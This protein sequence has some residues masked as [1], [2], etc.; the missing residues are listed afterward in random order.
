MDSFVLEVSSGMNKETSI[1]LEHLES[2][3][4]APVIRNLI[5]MGG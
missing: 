5:R 1:T 2:D 4:D 3:L